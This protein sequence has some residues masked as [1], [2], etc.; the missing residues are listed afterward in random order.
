[1]PI[2]LHHRLLMAS[3]LLAASSMPALAQA[4]AAPQAGRTD[5]LNPAA[6]V[7]PVL[8]LSAFAAY[9]ALGDSQVGNW[10]AAN[11]TV[12]R[13]GGWRAYAREATAP[14][15]AAAPASAA[16]GQMTAAEPAPPA[17]ADAT[18]RSPAVHHGHGK[19]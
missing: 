3:V 10:P 5:P 2:P 16:P 14:A 11:Q 12:A 17:A 13:I 15:A 18:S 1:M 19:P 7:P 9:R 6:E 4:P 8:H